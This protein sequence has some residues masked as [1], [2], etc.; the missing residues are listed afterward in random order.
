VFFLEVLKILLVIISNASQNP[1]IALTSDWKRVVKNGN[2]FF[3]GSSS[4]CRTDR[5]GRSHYGMF[6]GTDDCQFHMKIAQLLPYYR[7][8]TVKSSDNPK[9]RWTC[10]VFFLFSFFICIF[11]SLLASFS[12]YASLFVLLFI[13]IKFF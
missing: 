7:K 13:L 12:F 1:P 2:L 5:H 3:F 4:G 8:F 11:L 10:L 6:R 9:L